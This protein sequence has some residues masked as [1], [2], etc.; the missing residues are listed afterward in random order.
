MTE[1]RSFIQAG[2]TTQPGY[3]HD[4]TFDVGK[5]ATRIMSYQIKQD[6]G[7]EVVFIELS[8]GTVTLRTVNTGMDISY[9][10]SVI[11][12]V[13]YEEEQDANK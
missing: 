4:Y 11:V 13:A 1:I 12:Y 8:E 6:K 7:L 5:E 9:P 2:V 3:T 10:D